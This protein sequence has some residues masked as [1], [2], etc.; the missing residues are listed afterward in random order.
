[1]VVLSTVVVSVTLATWL[2]TELSA[3]L[4]V[5]FIV[6]APEMDELIVTRLE[7][8]LA[9]EL[10]TLSTVVLMNTTEVL[11]L[12]RL[13]LIPITDKLTVPSALL[14]WLT[15]LLVVERLPA[16]PAMEAELVAVDTERLATLVAVPASEEATLVTP[17][18]AS[19]ISPV[20][21]TVIVDNA[22]DTVTREVL[23][24]TCE[25]ETLAT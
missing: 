9:T 4:T 21:L 17:E 10:L 13:E 23:V 6:S 7:L 1:M 19:A 18:L 14:T 25:D 11:T 8:T 2:V 12:P 24:A 16:R 22:E 15:L 5:V 3:L 20:R